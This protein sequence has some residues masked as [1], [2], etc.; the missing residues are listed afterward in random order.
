MLITIGPSED[1]PT[2]A[3]PSTSQELQRRAL[4]IEGFPSSE[5]WN[6]F[7]KKGNGYQC[8]LADPSTL[9]QELQSSPWTNYDDLESWGWIDDI[10]LDSESGDGSDQDAGDEDDTGYEEIE[11]P[12]DEEVSSHDG[13]VFEGDKPESETDAASDRGSLFEEDEDPVA[14]GDDE[15]PSIRQMVEGQVARTFNLRHKLRTTGDDREEGKNYP[16]S[17]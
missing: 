9:P 10:R 15:E 16:V 2:S 13:S 4:D 5:T 14:G 6:K 17:I 3:D 1:A 7:G 8:S 11:D 12:S